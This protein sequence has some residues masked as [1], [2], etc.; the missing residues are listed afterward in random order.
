MRRNVVLIDFESVQP[1]SLSP[2][3]EDHF[4]IYLFVGANQARLPFELASAVQKLGSRAQYIK[5]TGNG[6]NA[7]DFHIAY[8]I[9]KLAADDAGAFF[10]IISRDK[11]FDPLIAHLKTR[12]IFAGRWESIGDIP[13]VKNAN[14]KSASEIAEI[15]VAKLR[16]PKVTR[17]RTEKTLA[18]ALKTHFRDALEEEAIPH[19][20]KA[21]QATGFLSITAGKITYAPTDG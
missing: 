3:M 15:F 18:S 21:I 20:I 8:Y 13:I 10:H 19:V 14:R 1:D 11:G 5:I 16:E 7:L 9:G 6:P 4:H 2:L 12:K 17:P